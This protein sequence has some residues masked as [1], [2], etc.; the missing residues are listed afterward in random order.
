M[1][2]AFPGCDCIACKARRS[3][4]HGIRCACTVC[5]AIRDIERPVPTREDFEAYFLANTSGRQRQ[6]RKTITKQ[7][8]TRCY[9]EDCTQGRRLARARRHLR[10]GNGL[11]IVAILVGLA[12][13]LLRP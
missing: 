13:L 7:Q 4:A 8:A 6:M 1:L 10:I 5:R 2:A 3:A 12:L 11:A 9:C